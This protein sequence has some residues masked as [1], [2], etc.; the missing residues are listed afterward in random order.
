MGV[1][2]SL[3]LCGQTGEAHIFLLSAVISRL[4]LMMRSRRS[5]CSSS[6]SRKFSKIEIVGLFDSVESILTTACPS[7]ERFVPIEEVDVRGVGEGGDEGR[8]QELQH[9]GS[10][11][12]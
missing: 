9:W 6:S 11:K 7:Q 1:L 4:A 12:R 10:D 5:W 8:T 3:S 2:V